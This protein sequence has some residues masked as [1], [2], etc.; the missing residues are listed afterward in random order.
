M[1][2]N[3]NHAPLFR[4]FIEGAGSNSWEK[5]IREG[6]YLRDACAS[7]IDASHFHAF[8]QRTLRRS[9]SGA[10]VLFTEVDSYLAVTG[11]CPSIWDLRAQVVSLGER[12][13]CSEEMIQEALNLLAEVE[14]FQP[15]PESFDWAV[16]QSRAQTERDEL[17]ENLARAG[18][19]GSQDPTAA[20]DFLAT[21][22][23]SRPTRTAITTWAEVAEERV[24]RYVE[25]DGTG[26]IG[27]PLGIQALDSRTG[28]LGKGELCL[29]FGR[30]K[31]GKSWLATYI[32]KNI[33]DRNL[34]LLLYSG[35][36]RINTYLDRICGLTLGI[37]PL[38][39]RKGKIPN[40]EDESKYL[41]LSRQAAHNHIGQ[42][43]SFLRAPRITLSQLES[44]ILQAEDRR[45]RKFDLVI[46]DPIYKLRSG[47]Q[48][49]G[50]DYEWAQMADVAS[51]VKDLAETLDVPIIATHQIT[52]D[53]EINK[54]HGGAAAKY[55]DAF[56]D[57]C[58]YMLELTAKPHGEWEILMSGGRHCEDNWSFI[59]LV[60][61]EKGQILEP[62]SA[63][64]A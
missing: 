14:G 21:L 43:F 23:R 17:F 10:S 63:R 46:L 54:L 18:Q 53:A 57:E 49:S 39:I 31:R 11:Q 22:S 34:N 47:T 60:D 50:P 5:P 35:E 40:T 42:N 56:G 2:A 45:Q 30:Q 48:A 9:A 51:G 15:R 6:K 62:V 26:M 20:L 27:L 32:A 33:L 13:S 59:L 64:R 12:G 29:I 41:E 19:M 24:Q 7:G 16:Q 44:V 28:G 52:R 4:Y 1:G 36:M 38:L 8:R 61:M 3:M 58:D 25:S 55:S 37:D